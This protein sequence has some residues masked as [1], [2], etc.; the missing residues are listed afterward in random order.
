MNIISLW[1]ICDN[2]ALV[3]DMISCK[4]NEGI[5]SLSLFVYQKIYIVRADFLDA[6]Q[7]CIKR[8]NNDRSITTYVFKDTL[9]ARNL[10][11]NL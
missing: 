4:R 6:H 9:L 3:Q 11:E 7:V 5:C 2:H 1:S 10:R 8:I